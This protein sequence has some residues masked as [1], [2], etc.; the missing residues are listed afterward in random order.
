MARYPNKDYFK[1]GTCNTIDDVTDLKVKLD[2]TSKRWDGTQ[3]GP[4]NWEPRQPQD[5]PVTPRPNRVY[6]NARTDRADPVPD[7]LTLDD[8]WGL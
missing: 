6:G 3:T 8:N 7:P 2:S 4:K 1:F 5:F